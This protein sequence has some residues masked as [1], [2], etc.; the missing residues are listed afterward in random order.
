MLETYIPYMN[1]TDGLLI[2]Q[3]SRNSRGQIHHAYMVCGVRRP[4]DVYTD[5]EA[6]EM[7]VI[8]MAC[9]KVWR[10]LITDRAS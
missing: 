1:P 6:N 4:C 9:P 5:M 2:C 3:V 10:S 7:L 8:R